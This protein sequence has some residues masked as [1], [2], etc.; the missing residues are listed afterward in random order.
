MDPKKILKDLVYRISITNKNDPEYENAVR[1][2]DRLLE[3]FN[4]TIDD[5]DIEERNEILFENLKNLEPG[6]VANYFGATLKTDIFKEPYKLTHYKYNDKRK[7]NLSVVGVFLTKEESQ[8]AKPYVEN[9]LKMFRR[10]F[11]KFNNELEKDIESKRKAFRYSFLSKANLLCDAEDD[12]QERP[13]EFD[14][15]D[16]I[17]AA[18][19]LEN[20]IFPKNHIK[21]E[22]RLIEG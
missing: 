3:K 19:H 9:L 4:L 12:D 18:K 10:E 17:K 1:L 8:K 15:S 14:L 6:I 11:E 13:A 20:L 16:V 7:K 22:Q 5:L 21:H 2:R